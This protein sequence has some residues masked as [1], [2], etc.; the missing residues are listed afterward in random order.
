M[1]IRHGCR[2]PKRQAGRPT[3]QAP[4]TRQR[5]GRRKA[6]AIRSVVASAI[7]A[8]IAVNTPLPGAVGEALGLGSSQP[9]RS[10]FVG[11][12]MSAG[13]SVRADAHVISSP[14]SYDAG[15]HGRVMLGAVERAQAELIDPTWYVRPDDGEGVV[16]SSCSSIAGAIGGFQVG[17]NP[18]T[19]T[20][21]EAVGRVK[22]GSGQQ[23]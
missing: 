23:P 22:S 16:V 14:G 7:L 20:G 13:Y 21:L 8:A 3:R 2:L 5:Q 1:P 19:H 9:S 17:S 18:D 12:C 11:H 6:F 15:K 10:P 4:S